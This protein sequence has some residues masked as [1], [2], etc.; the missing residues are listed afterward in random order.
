MK[1]NKPRRLRRERDNSCQQAEHAKLCF[2][3]L[4]PQKRKPLEVLDFQHRGHFSFICLWVF[5]FCL[6]LLLFLLRTVTPSVREDLTLLHS[7]AF[8]VR[9]CEKK[10][11][12]GR[13]VTSPCFFSAMPQLQM[14]S[15]VITSSS[16]V[17][18]KMS[19]GHIDLPT[20][21]SPGFSFTVRLKG[22]RDKGRQTVT[23][24]QTVI[25]TDTVIET[26][27]SDRQIGTDL[28]GLR[29]CMTLSCR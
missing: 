13:G 9:W 8:T 29:I 14:L 27:S 19:F 16:A 1:M 23:E 3:L 5:V 26:D 22:F 12:W 15:S 2:D 25:Q 7:W 17:M 4:Q 18:P 10:G 6:V 24:T 28:K 21:M 11:S 20:C